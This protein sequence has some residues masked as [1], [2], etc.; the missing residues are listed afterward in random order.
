MSKSPSTSQLQNRLPSHERVDQACELA[1]ELLAAPRTAVETKEAAKMARL[2]AD[3]VGKELTFHLADEVFRPPSASAQAAAFRRLVKTHGVPKY[4]RPHER[5][6]MHLGAF[7]SRFLPGIVMPAVTAQ[8][9]KDS[10]RVILAREDKPLSAYFTKRP[11]VNLNLLGEA[12][13]GEQEAQNRLEQNLELLAK[14]ECH[15]LSV[16]ISAI[17]SQINLLDQE[18]TLAA[19]QTRLRRLYRTGKFINL[20]MEEYRDLDLTCEAF[21][22]TLGEPEFESLEAGIVLQAYLPDSYQALQDLT[23]WAKTRKTAIKIRIVKG[24][25][26]AMEKV[27]ASQHHWEQ[28]PYDDKTDVDANYKRLLHFAMLPENAQ[29]VR[30]GVASHNLF[31]IAYALLLR[32]ENG[33]ETRVELE[34]LEGMANE[35]ARA[36]DTKGSPVLFYAPIV[37]KENFH[38]AIA[39]LIRRLDEN[40]SPENFLAHIFSMKPGDAA[41]KE[42]EARF[43]DSC[44][45]IPTVKTGP[46]RTQNR[47][48]VA[49]DT[50]SPFENSPETDWVLPVNRAW[51]DQA[52]SSY[53]P[54]TPPALADMEGVRAALETAAACRWSDTTPSE[55]AELLRDAAT[56]LEGARGR[57]IACMRLDA[58]KRP[59]EADVEISEAVDFANYYAD[60]TLD[61][62]FLDGTS[63]TPLGTIVVTPPWNFP[64]AIPCGGILA[65]LAAGN[66]VI[67][68]PAPEV[69]QTAW[70]MVRCLWKAGI[71]REALQFL[72][73]PDNEVGQFL[74]SSSRVAGV[75]LTGSTLTADLFQSWNQDLEL[76]AETS[77]KNALIITSSSD[78][79]LAIKDLVRSAFGH[80]GQKCSAASLALIEADLYD[81]PT[82]MAQLR[83]AAASLPIGEATDPAA[84]V[85]PLIQEPGPDLLRGLTQL[86]DG[87]TWLLEPQRHGPNLWSPGI[88]LGVKTGSWI[89]QTELFGPVLALI[90]VE[91]L[92]E[93]ITIQNSSDF[94]LTGGIHSLDPGEIAQWRESVEVG[95]AYINRPITGAIVRRQPFG[96]W[97]RSSV[98]PGAKAGG[99]NYLTQFSHWQENKLPARQAEPE[100]HVLEL[101]RELGSEER[102]VAAARSYAYWWR[103]EF[104]KEHD[105]S[106]L[107]GETNHFR[108]RVAPEI[109][110]ENPSK[111]QIIAAATVGTKVVDHSSHPLAKQLPENA[112]SNGRLELLNYLH[113]QSISE[114][115]HRHGR[116][117]N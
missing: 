25:N 9:R 37:K 12:I 4:L 28:A 113:E 70:E 44:T 62:D 51:L 63:P 74:V 15:S 26:L 56:E 30:I 52:I 84:I 38:S 27:E 58:A 64:C 1:A 117:A 29:H 86:D 114:T 7:A 41:F 10:Q 3:P 17:F 21:K 82:F 22:R 112:L 109:V 93:A 24:A 43:R 104:S 107:L 14:P 11:R 35:H 87:E 81:S 46:N 36:L 85:T 6:L 79:D 116:I 65:A 57:L 76:F 67:I 60:R 8:I 47:F 5:A 68:K 95:N 88:R 54:D 96:G 90:R 73:C 49:P 110:I 45:R 40:T 92:E 106:N 100:P 91:T 16:K 19:I 77:G 66:P 102:L 23:A 31:D 61:T 89:H 103:E 75:I 55:R 78:P 48:L 99:P 59:F 101:L 71:P 115:T 42:Q 2:L 97:K 39:Y 13:L 18:G 33:V 34:M 98:G 94:G 83:D 69:I 111:L 108:Y 20:D 80:A 53:E 32:E 50:S 105:P 72:P